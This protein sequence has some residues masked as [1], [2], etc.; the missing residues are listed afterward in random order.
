MKNIHANEQILRANVDIWSSFGYNTVPAPACIK[1][2]ISKI[3]FMQ[4]FL[5]G[6]ATGVE[7]N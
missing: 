3:K 2:N 4:S 1:I 6:E 7:R 5:R